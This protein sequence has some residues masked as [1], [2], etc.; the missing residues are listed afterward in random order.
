[1]DE[2]IWW[3]RL[4]SEERRKRIRR[5]QRNKPLLQALDL[6]IQWRGLWKP[7][8]CSQIERFLALKSSEVQLSSVSENFDW[9]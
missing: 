3:A 5:M 9:T 7:L 6:L 1:M 2:L 8:N 4:P